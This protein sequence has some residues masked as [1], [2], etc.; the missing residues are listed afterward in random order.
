MTICAVG[1]GAAAWSVAIVLAIVSSVNEQ[2]AHI[3]TPWLLVALAL[4]VIA[5]LSV[6]IER[7]RDQALR[8]IHAEFEGEVSDRHLSAV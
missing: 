1:L 7:S 2:M 6:M 4:G 5:A 3:V 8:H